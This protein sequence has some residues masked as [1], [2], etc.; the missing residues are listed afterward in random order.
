M[1][2]PTVATIEIHVEDGEFFEAEFSIEPNPEPELP[3]NPAEP[4]EA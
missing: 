1:T 4:S 3:T 2:E